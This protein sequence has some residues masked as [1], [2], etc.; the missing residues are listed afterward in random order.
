MCTTD[1]SK[2]F[3]SV[4][5]MQ[6][7]NA[8]LHNGVSSS[9]VST[10]KFCYGNLTVLAKWKGTISDPA[11]NRRGVRQGSVLSPLI[12]EHAISRILD[13]IS[14][15]LLLHCTDLSYLA[16]ADDAPLLSRSKADLRDDLN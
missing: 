12:F 1:I 14:P 13:R 15:F 7:M 2:A 10:L 4:N 3:D 9:I 5:H 11:K 16:F 6:A 8:L